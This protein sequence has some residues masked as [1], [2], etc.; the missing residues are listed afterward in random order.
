MVLNLIARRLVEN[1]HA[2]PRITAMPST[3]VH[4]P[5]SHPPAIV[6]RA[7]D[8]AR[9]WW[10]FLRSL[11]ANEIAAGDEYLRF[12]K[13]CVAIVVNGGQRFTDF[14]A[15]SDSFV[16]FQTDAMIDLV[17]LLFASAAKHGERDAESL[18]VGAGDKT[19]GRTR[20]VKIQARD[21]QA[22]R[23]V[24]DAFI[25]AL[26]ANPLAAFFE[27]RA[28]G[29][30]GLGEAAAFFDGLR[31]LT[32]ITHPRREG[33]VHVAPIGRPAASEAFDG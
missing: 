12:G 31:S 5:M 28:G 15:I 21:G 23:L 1:S 29:D 27:R 6:L 8:P 17:F 33:E 22:F 26:Q 16:E 7:D 9:Q 11:F 32:E 2:N 24:N 13:L 25:A 3:P 14:H 18:A 4:L 10:F 20:Y 30:H 19:T